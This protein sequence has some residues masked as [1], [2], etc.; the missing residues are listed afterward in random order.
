M[1]E[2]KVSEG[3]VDYRYH[4]YLCACGVFGVYAC[5]C[6]HIH[7]G[8]HA[9]VRRCKCWPEVHVS[10]LHQW[11]AIF[12]LRLVRASNITWSSLICL[13]YRETL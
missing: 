10:C 7:V 5:V 3:K 12:F 1:T 6:A 2:N 8:A 13:D 9:H 11:T 4:Q